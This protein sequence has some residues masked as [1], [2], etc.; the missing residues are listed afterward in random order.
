MDIPQLILIA[1]VV[2]LVAAALAWFG[3]RAKQW[4]TNDGQPTEEAKPF[5]TL[6]DE[7]DDAFDDERDFEGNDDHRQA[8]PP[9][10]P[11]G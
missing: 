9:E 2:A 8:P 3:P 7:D 5:Q 10:G 6:P 1:L 11:A 4:R